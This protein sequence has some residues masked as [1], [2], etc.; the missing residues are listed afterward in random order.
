MS[1]IKGG[2]AGSLI[3]QVAGYNCALPTTVEGSQPAPIDWKFP[4]KIR[5][6]DASGHWYKV[7]ESY[8]ATSETMI[9]DISTMEKE[10][11]D[12]AVMAYAITTAID[13]IANGRGWVIFEGQGRYSVRGVHLEE[14]AINNMVIGLSLRCPIVDMNRIVK[15]VGGARDWI[16]D[17]VRDMTMVEAGWLFGN[18]RL[19]DDQRPYL[20]DNN[21]I[22]FHLATQ[23]VIGVTSHPNTR[24]T[25][26]EIHKLPAKRV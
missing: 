15:V 10:L 7:R 13:R 12:R 24:D 8:K 4:N 22:V 21:R 18:I 5:R 16:S 26:C 1:G 17:R 9:N 25:R 11:G 14:D 3:T 23:K 19:K 20:V 2:P 6:S